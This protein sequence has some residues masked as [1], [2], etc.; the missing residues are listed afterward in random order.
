MQ[1]GRQGRLLIVLRFQS[2]PRLKIGFFFRLLSL[3]V[4]GVARD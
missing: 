4:C 2:A 3:S 1:L